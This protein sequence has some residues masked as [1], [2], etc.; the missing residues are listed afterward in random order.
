VRC[1]NGAADSRAPAADAFRARTPEA[2]IE[3]L[4][5]NSGYGGFGGRTGNVLLAF[6]LE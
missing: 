5:V 3:A 1:H 6:G 2:I 4:Y